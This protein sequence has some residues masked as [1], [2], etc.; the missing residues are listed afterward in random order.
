V[1]W[2]SDKAREIA[3]RLGPLTGEKVIGVTERAI[4]ETL[5]AA[6]ETGRAEVAERIGGLLGRD[7]MAEREIADGVAAAIRKLGEPSAA[8][9]TYGADGYRMQTDPSSV[10]RVPAVHASGSEAEEAGTVSDDAKPAHPPPWRW[11]GIGN[12]DWSLRDADGNEL[13]GA[14]NSE[15]CAVY[16]P[17]VRAQTEAAPE[18]EA[19]LRKHQ[20]S[21]HGGDGATECPECGGSDRHFPD[22]DLGSLLARLDEARSRKP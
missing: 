4:R 22:C 11:V 6:A 3:D 10:W 7:G 17:V 13:I 1:S 21:G 5:A 18:L 9:K 20:F 16:S 12:D 19:Q 8:Y 2:A 14:T 15:T